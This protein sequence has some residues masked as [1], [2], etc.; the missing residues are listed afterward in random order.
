VVTT[1]D[2]RSPAETTEGNERCCR[3][4]VPVDEAAVATDVDV[5]SAMGNETRY[6][7]LRLVAGA[8]E[9]VCVCE[10]HPALDVSQ[11]AVSQA[12]ARLH[13]AGLVTRRTEGR[14]RYYSATPTA[15]RLLDTL[16]DVRG[17]RRA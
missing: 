9:G 2:S 10:L 5:L 6:E 11:S 1:I 8:D 17:E 15:E 13:G 12:L 16:D 7:A 3:S 14:W 4:Q